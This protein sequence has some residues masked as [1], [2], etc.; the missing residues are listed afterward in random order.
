M[1]PESQAESLIISPLTLLLS[2]EHRHTSCSRHGFSFR[3]CR[4]FCGYTLRAPDLSK[5]RLLP[6]MGLVQPASFSV[7]FFSRPVLL[8]GA[9][10]EWDVNDSL[11]AQPV[12]VA[13]V[14]DH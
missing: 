9:T 4:P 11:V 12:N 8:G 13:C 6:L 3:I 2:L 7:F 10:A 5:S 14:M 1:Y